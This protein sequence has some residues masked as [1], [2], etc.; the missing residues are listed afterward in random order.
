M[1]SIRCLLM[2]IPLLLNACNSSK[3]EDRR[4][5]LAKVGGETIYLDEAL[6]CMPAGLSRKDSTAFVKQFLQNHIKEMLVYEKAEKNISQSQELKYLVEN[7]RRSLIINEYQ[8]KALN[9]KLQTDISET[10]MMDFYK[11]N[12]SRFFAE[13]NLVK[14]MYLKVPG[15]VPEIEN[16]KKWYKSSSP[17]ALEK[18]EKFCI[19]NGGYF[20]YFYDKWVSFDDVLN[21]IP[22]AV[23]N[24]TDFLKNRSTL[25]V[26]GKD[27][28]YLLYIKDYVLSGD[29]A[30]FE[31]V[32]SDVK[33]LML[34]SKKA[35]FLNQIEQD[36]LKEAQK[37]R[38]ITY[39]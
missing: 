33:N 16:L 23:S 18:I 37:K 12:S 3:N 17:E 11:S 4:I 26:K 20:E 10:D 19:Q 15:N 6:S 24:Q 29:I 31:Y 36:L 27:Y 7:Y 21:N 8:Q 38:E 1:R 34:N 2:L 39:Y 22:K 13:K 28:Y 5:R 35:E 9:E 32:K 30:P 14:G 25:E